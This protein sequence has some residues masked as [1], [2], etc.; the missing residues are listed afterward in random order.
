MNL[1][2]ECV[3]F[4]GTLASMTRKQAQSVVLSLKG[5][6]KTSVTQETTLLVIGSCQSDLFAENYHTQKLKEANRLKSEGQEI[7]FM[8]EQEFLQFIT[9]H[10]QLL[11][12]NL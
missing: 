1:E 4:T 12:S 5:A 6:N 11:L 7:Q 3:V 10:F 8:S 9:Q 2:N